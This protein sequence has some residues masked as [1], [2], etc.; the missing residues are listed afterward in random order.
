MRRIPVGLNPEHFEW[1]TEQS[2]RLGLSIAAYMRLLVTHDRYHGGITVISL[3]VP[4]D[5]SSSD[6]SESLIE[7]NA[8]YARVR[9]DPGARYNQSTSKSWRGSAISQSE[10]AKVVDET[11]SAGTHTRARSLDGAPE[12]EGQVESPSAS[13]FQAPAERRAQPEAEAVEVLDP[14]E[15]ER[16]FAELVERHGGKG[17]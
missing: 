8:P 1:L 3:P 7:G 14:V 9:A 6:D 10:S 15:D 17:A 5:G 13:G 16:I 4:S 2:Q 11:Q 12:D